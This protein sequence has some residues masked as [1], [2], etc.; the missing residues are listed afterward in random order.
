MTTDATVNPTD[1]VMPSTGTP[2]PSAGEAK[3]TFTLEEVTKMVNERHSTLDSKIAAMQAEVNLGRLAGVE[4]AATK[5]K[6]SAIDDTSDDLL[7]KTEGGVDVA[8]ERQ[9]VREERRL[10]EEQK[11]KQDWEW[12]SRQDA[13]LQADNLAKL[14]TL[15]EVAK[16]YKV[17]VNQ[18]MQLP[19][20][21]A[22]SIRV[23]A[24]VLAQAQTPVAQMP[25]DSG[26]N[27]GGGT[28]MTWDE[29]KA[30]YAAGTVSYETYSASRPTSYM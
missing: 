1:A 16:E 13:L 7:A 3:T 6:L 18:L 27:T 2:E 23:S 14:V 10:F 25:V 20:D 21:S 29:I 4:L 28:N 26:K 11:Q 12:L 17:D 9:K 8:K 5:S 22:Q 15:S 24:Q 19:S 30:G